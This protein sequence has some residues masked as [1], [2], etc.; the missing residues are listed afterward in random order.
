MTELPK[1][2][3]KIK[4]FGK[5]FLPVYLGTWSISA[6]L[7]ILTANHLGNGVNETILAVIGLI[8]I[9]AVLLALLNPVSVVICAMT[10]AALIS[11][12]LFCRKTDENGSLKISRDKL[13][14]IMILGTVIT[15]IIGTAVFILNAGTLWNFLTV[16]K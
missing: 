7:F 15:L 13:T 16:S 9:G 2:F 4:D 6:V 5:V 8:F 12:R 10:T 1:W 14:L 3:I 11:D